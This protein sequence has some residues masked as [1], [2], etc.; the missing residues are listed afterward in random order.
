MRLA[1]NLAE[2]RQSADYALPCI[3]A[4]GRLTL[5]ADILG[6]VKLGL[7]RR[8]DPLGNLV[9]HR[10]DVAE[11]AVVAFGP[12]VIA[13]L[14]LDQLGSYAQ[15]IAAL[16][17]TAFEDITHAELAADLLHIDRAALVGKA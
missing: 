5:A 7:D 13:R 17:D 6:R 12:D 2:R 15:P 10:E 1:C 11:V 16:P 4:L 3:E 9:L 14:G 8:H